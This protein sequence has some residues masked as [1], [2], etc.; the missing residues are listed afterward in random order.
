MT[1]VRFRLMD[2]IGPAGE[3]PEH[4]KS[5]AAGIEPAK[6]PADLQVVHAKALW[7]TPP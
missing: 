3:S 5:E 7:D 2:E 4:D 1:R 6:D